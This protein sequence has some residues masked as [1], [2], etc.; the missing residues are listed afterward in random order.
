MCGKGCGAGSGPESISQG[1]LETLARASLLV[2]GGVPNPQGPTEK[3][4]RAMSQGR[5]W[6]Q[7]PKSQGGSHMDSAGPTLD[8]MLNLPNC[9]PGSQ[10]SQ[11]SFCP[12]GTSSWFGGGVLG[13]LFP[14]C[15]PSV[16]D[17]HDIGASL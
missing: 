6:T 5:P 7:V 11:G 2:A 1:P 9:D 8:G 4:E 13:K 12:C 17:H 15:D 16:L 14:S 3:E 10:A